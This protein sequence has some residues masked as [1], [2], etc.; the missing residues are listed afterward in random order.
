MRALVS[1]LVMTLT[2]PIGGV[3]AGSDSEIDVAAEEVTKTEQ[4]ATEEPT[5]GPELDEDVTA[6]EVTPKADEKEP[7]EAA[8]ENPKP[9]NRLGAI[10]PLAADDDPI[11]PLAAPDL[12]IAISIISDGT[13]A[14]DAATFDPATGQNAGDDAGANN[15]VVRV[16]DTVRYQ[17]QYSSAGTVAENA[18]FTLRFPKGMVLEAGMPPYCDPATSSLTPSTIASPVPMTATS[19][20]ALPEQTLV[21][22]VGTLE[23]GT[24]FEQLD[25]KVLNATHNNTVLPVLEAS[26]T[27]D[28]VDQ[29][30]HAPTLP[31]VVATARLKW[32]ISKQGMVPSPANA[33]HAFTTCLFDP[34]RYCY[35]AAY[36][37]LISAPTDG[38]GAMPAIGDVTFV[39]DVSAG[40]FYTNLDAAA[41][42]AIDADPDKYGARVSAGGVIVAQPNSRIVQPSQTAADSV[43]N[44]GTLT[45]DQPVPGQ[46]ATVTLSGTD[47]SLQ[48]IPSQARNGTPVPAGQAYAV[49]TSIR[50]EIPRETMVDFGVVINSS[51][52]LRM[53]NSYTDLRIE[54]FDPDAGDVLTSADQPTAND[55][56]PGVAT[57]ASG[58]GGSISKSFAGVPGAPGNMTGLSYSSGVGSPV[59]P[60]G[61]AV[62][63]SGEVIVA[64]GQDVVSLLQVSGS[65]IENP[66]V[67]SVVA[68]DT[69]DNSR[70]YLRRDTNTTPTTGSAGQ[71]QRVPGVNRT[72]WVSGYNN[73]PNGNTTRWAETDPET[74]DIVVEYAAGPAAGSGADS[75]CGDDKGP[76]VT[77]PDDPSLGNDPALAAQGIY[78]GVNRVRVH[79]VLPEPASIAVTPTNRV[80][81]FVSIAMRVADTGNPS[82]DILPNWASDKRVDFQNV[83]MRTV[84]DDPGAW[85]R[86]TYDPQ[87][88]TGSRGDRLK[89]ANAMVRVEKEIRRG[90]S[91]AFQ[92]T[93]GLSVVAG[94]TVQYRL[95]PT[96]NSPAQA[97]VTQ[98]VWIEDCLPA[99]HNFT[100]AA[101]LPAGTQFLH[102][103]T[104]PADAKRD[105]C[106]PGE[107][108]LRWILPDM[109][110]NQPIEPIIVTTDI[111]QGAPSGAYLNTVEVWTADDPSPASV[112]HANAGAQVT[113]RASMQISKTA[114]TPLVQV[115]PLGNDELET[116]RW[117]VKLRNSQP[118]T[119]PPVS[120][121]DIIDVLPA[122]GRNG[123]DFSGTFEFVGVSGVTAGATVWY[124]SDPGV[125][126]DPQDP[127]NA[128][129]GAT[130]WCDAPSDGALMSGAGACPASVADVTGIRVQKPGAFP[131]G[132]EIVFEIEMVAKGNAAGD[133]YANQVI[134]RATGFE[135]PVGPIVRVERAEASAV[136]DYVWW[137]F[138]RDG[139]QNDFNGAPEPAASGVTVRLTGR[140]DLGNPV[141][142]ETTTD[143]DG[144]YEFTG[145]RSSDADGYTV[146]FVPAPGT[147]FT[148]ARTGGDDATDSDADPATGEVTID[149]PRNT[150]I[151]TVDAGLLAEGGLR[152]QKLL[153]GAG[154]GTVS[155]GDALRFDVQCTFNGVPVID[156]HDLRLN[157]ATGQIT[158]TSD[159]IEPLPAFTECVV[160]ELESA[161]ADDVASDPVVVTVPWDAA[162]ERAGVVT[163]SITNYYSAGTVRLEKEIEGEP[164][165]VAAKA[166]TLFEILVTCQIEENGAPVDRFSR[167]VS[168][169]GGES[170]LLEASDGE[171]V[172]LP[173]GTRCFAEEI[174][175]GGANSVTIDHD[176]FDNGVEVQG[177][178]PEDLQELTI[179]VINSFELPEGAL[180]ISK[181]LS[182]VGVKPFGGDDEFTFS[183]V[184]TYEGTTV[185]DE[186]ITLSAAGSDAILSDAMGP[187]LATTSCTVTETAAGNADT[188]AGSVTVVIPWNPETWT[189]GDVVASLTNYYSAGSIMVNKELAG[190]KEAIEFMTDAV[191]EILVTCQIEESDGVRATLYMGT[192]KLKGGQTKMLVTDDGD[193]RALPIGTRCFAQETVDG[194]ADQVVIDAT[195]Y[196]NAVRV[197]SGTP[198]DLQALRIRVVNVFE[199]DD[200]TC[201]DG[202]GGGDT[203]DPTSPEEPSATD[204]GRLAVTGAEGATLVALGAVALGAVVLGFFLA[205]RRTRRDT[206]AE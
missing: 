160:T 128:P 80:V 143:A 106:A 35:S 165:A 113:A 145:L 98:D 206:V 73:I 96:L 71:A 68:C 144:R 123:T 140:D 39:D 93:T 14:W 94:D 57:T 102:A 47:W 172:M 203:E 178:T 197:E 156:E 130:A 64:E 87:T 184:C 82:G 121:P 138:N 116:N 198:D 157:V 85:T 134:A 34:T 120:N 146:T 176:S 111:S 13:A 49:S 174:E 17:L 28:G 30:V 139:I 173:L 45:I 109:V 119:A 149:V 114:L 105:A 117:S 59:G 141:S 86:S 89:L 104:T 55:S 147:P 76:W 159:V 200:V 103:A 188:A 4:V 83:D 42:A 15:G 81:A 148:D 23:A 36:S 163:A 54:G 75:E 7:A 131:T 84:L 122:Q 190:D 100:S 10:A 182:G 137:D 1:A 2:F 164:A 161:L 40:A 205:T 60:P 24:A 70:L 110:V 129:G 12:S 189:S 5:T 92:K 185:Y 204:D 61:D 48:T 63:Y 195:D 9:S 186:E 18:T 133:V 118:E 53:Q 192:V 50:V 95:T 77:D 72:V 153:E 21:C 183:V 26:L 162:A 16:N 181:L 177:G 65:H 3:A 41:I 126:A 20:D 150:V 91:D 112:R 199:C 115:N 155:D 196:D 151:T 169:R 79:I 43:R 99:E 168:L 124:T 32:D 6:E 101:P 33:N 175:D 90:E 167:V 166:G 31:E 152:V 74:P 135:F 37:L 22:N 11:S 67:T 187:F 191:F 38:K 179:R 136:G 56:R 8:R 201:A 51:R 19:I 154:A 180:R 107:T 27:A 58:V 171:A 88:H 170:V 46:P 97:E 78:T 194:G 158:A 125:Q 202:V 66:A 108:Y 52:Q 142:H 127:S 132:A 69:W 25:V 62:R 29:P 44:S 193:V